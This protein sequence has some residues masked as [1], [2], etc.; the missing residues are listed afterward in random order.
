MKSIN[1]VSIVD[2]VYQIVTKELPGSDTKILFIPTNPANREYYREFGVGFHA[3]T[4]GTGK[5]IVSIDPTFENWRQ[6]IHYPLAH[7]YRHSV[8]MLRNFKTTDLTSLE[9]I[10]LEGK[11]DL[12]A[13]KIFLKS[14]IR[15]GICWI[16][17]M[18]IGF[19]I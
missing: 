6:Y 11:D 17:K 13:K 9:Y 7:E 4:F 16:V 18:R 15:L 1:F 5:I 10:I 14:I 19:G 8:W 3:F 2:S 12:F